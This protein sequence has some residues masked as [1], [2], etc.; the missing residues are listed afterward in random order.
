MASYRK[1]ESSSSRLSPASPSAV[2]PDVG[3]KTPLTAVEKYRLLRETRRVLR[4]ER[5]AEGRKSA[6]R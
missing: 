1:S 5:L 4:R 2:S 6:L 3:D